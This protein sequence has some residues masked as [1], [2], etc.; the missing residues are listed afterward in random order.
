MTS[1]IEDIPVQLQPAANAAL[2]WIN[3]KNRANFKL[4][5][6][7]DPDV[8]WQPEEGASTEMALVLCDNE[9]CARE[10]VRIQLQGDGYQIAAIETEDSLI[11]PHLD[12]PANIRTGWLDAQ[13]RKHRFTVLV[14]Y[15]GFW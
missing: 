11:P 14:F 13:M 2:V 8:T 12:P 15:R 6:L 5:G 3:E 1:V 7:V 4:T 10:Q 9:T